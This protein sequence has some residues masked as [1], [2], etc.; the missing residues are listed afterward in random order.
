MSSPSCSSG[1][2]PCWP[3]EC[4]WGIAARA[5]TGSSTRVGSKPSGSSSRW[6][7]I[8][9]V[10]ARTVAGRPVGDDGAVRQDHR[11]LAQLQRVRQV[12]SDHE[13]GHV[14]ALEDLRHL[15]TG[16]RVEVGG[17]FVEDEDLRSHRQHR[18][19]GDPPALTEGQV[20]RWALRVRAHAHERQG[21]PHPG[22][23]LR[24]TQP[25]VVR[26]EGHVVPDR[27]H[28]QLVVGVLKDDPH[29]PPDLQEVLAGDGHSGDG[30]RPGG[31]LVNPVEVQDERRLARSVRTQQGYPLGAV[32][33][34]VDTGEGTSAIRVV[35][36]QATDIENGSAHRVTTQASSTHTAARRAEPTR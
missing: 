31:R 26:P 4:T 5:R 6:A 35:E 18:G 15:A 28:E 32:H 30:H 20:V 19:D 14:K 36:D 10:S 2:G 23:E 34:Q 7:A 9:S 22:L 24:S 27:R 29:P 13:D 8:V 33:M 12:V 3:D 1:Y 16:G 21:L 25:D 17:G 11:A